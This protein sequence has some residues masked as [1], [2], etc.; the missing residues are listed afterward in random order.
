MKSSNSITESA[1]V[2]RPGLSRLKRIVAGV[3]DLRTIEPHDEV[4]SAGFHLQGVPYVAR[5]LDRMV[6]KRATTTVD[7]VVDR[8]VVLQRIA[9]C[10]VVIVRI[11][12]A[13]H[14]SEA[15]ID[16]AGERSVG[17]ASTSGCTG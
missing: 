10:D 2:Q 6:L 9:T 4:I 15:L 17:R 5:D 3:E 8:A 13:P 1:F 11:A 14:D 16:N 12:V 7:D